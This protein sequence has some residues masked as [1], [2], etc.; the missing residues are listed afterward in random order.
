[1]MIDDNEYAAEEFKEV[2]DPLGES[3]FALLRKG[4]QKK[5][6]QEE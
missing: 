6:V 3:P 2:L 5:G 4:T 1:M